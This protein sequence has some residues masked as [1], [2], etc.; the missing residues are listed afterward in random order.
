MRLPPLDL[1]AQPLMPTVFITP[2]IF[3]YRDPRESTLPL[4]SLR[5]LTGFSPTGGPFMH[6]VR[7]EVFPPLA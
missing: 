4:P 7:G 6:L 3:T 2:P 5:R 1:R